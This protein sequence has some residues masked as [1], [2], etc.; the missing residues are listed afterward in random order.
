MSMKLYEQV[1]HAINKPD[2]VLRKTPKGVASNIAG[3]KRLRYYN[4]DPKTGKRVSH[5]TETH[6]P[7]GG[8]ERDTLQFKGIK[9]TWSHKKQ[10]GVYSREYPVKHVKDPMDLKPGEVSQELK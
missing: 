3:Y 7:R 5:S 8:V 1:S 2:G 9:S 4:N 6:H 10:P